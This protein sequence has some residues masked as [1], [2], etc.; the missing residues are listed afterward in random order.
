VSGTFISD[1]L[2]PAEVAGAEVYSDKVSGLLFDHFG[3]FEGFT[4]ESFAGDNHRFFSRETPILDLAKSASL[5][6]YV[7]FGV[8]RI[9]DLVAGGAGW[10]TP[11]DRL[12]RCQ[13]HRWQRN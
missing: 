11:R 8:A 10:T 6:R 13:K 2:P 5:E 12:Q 4:L 1:G 3:D 9:G 7:V